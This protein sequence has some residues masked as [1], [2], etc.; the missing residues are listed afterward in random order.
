MEVDALTM[1]VLSD[2]IERRV[3]IDPD[4]SYL[5]VIT[6]LTDELDIKHKEDIQKYL[7]PNLSPV[8]LAKLKV[9]AQKN[10]MLKDKHTTTDLMVL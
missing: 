5:T 8:I 6:E 1:E 2:E 9:E 10:Y 7:I 4:R 3:L